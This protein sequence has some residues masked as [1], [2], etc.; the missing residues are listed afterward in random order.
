MFCIHCGKEIADDLTICNLCGGAVQPVAEI[1]TAI[2][3]DPKWSAGDMF[4]LITASI[5]IPLVGIIFGMV[6]FNS[7]AKR[8]QAKIL[9]I[10]SISVTVLVIA[11]V[12][13]LAFFLHNH[14]IFPTHPTP[15]HSAPSPKITT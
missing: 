10:V 1:Q 14:P 2:S 13:Y 15:G 4:G 3:N 12:T 9:L 8:E 5:L 6:H 11:G 7:V